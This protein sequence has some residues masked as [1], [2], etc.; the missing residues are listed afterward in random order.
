MIDREKI[1][2][3]MPHRRKLE[4]LDM[5]LRGKVKNA[6]LDTNATDVRREEDRS[7]NA[8]DHNKWTQCVNICKVDA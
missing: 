2:M 8:D 1:N 7:T 6:R 4:M 3:S 5:A